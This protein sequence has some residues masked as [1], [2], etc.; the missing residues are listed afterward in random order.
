MASW[1]RE[2]LIAG[3][4]SILRKFEGSSSILTYLTVVI[5]NLYRDYNNHRWGRW[6]PSAE[7]KRLGEEAVL[8]ETFLQRDG[9]SFTEAVMQLRQ[10][11][12]TKRSDR[13]LAELSMRLPARYHPRIISDA[14]LHAMPAAESAEMD[15]F[16]EEA[17]AEWA[18]QQSALGAAL[19]GVSDEDRLILRMKFWDGLRVA[20]IA[21]TLNIEQKPLYRRID[22]LLVSLRGT[23]ERL[24]VDAEAVARHLEVE[25]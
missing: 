21:R 11:G 22:R 8:L 18:R 24:G 14:H 17:D 23:L 25:A 20:D 13:E 12:V 4:Y 5:A 9:F 15:L 6:R 10:R 2:K 7:A 3:E 1:I 16:R 19:D